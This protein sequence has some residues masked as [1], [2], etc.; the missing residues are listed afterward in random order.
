MRYSISRNDS[1]LIRSESTAKF[2]SRCSEVGTY[3]NEFNNSV[4]FFKK[5]V[6]FGA[7][8]TPPSLM[9][10]ELAS[11]GSPK[12]SS[13][14]DSCHELARLEENK[15]LQ[16]EC[17][18]LKNQLANLGEK[19]NNL[20][21]KYIQLKSKRRF[22]IEEIRGRLDASQ[23]HIQT[24][25]SQLSVQRQRL[26]AEEMFRK[27]VECDLRKV[28]EEKR[29]VCKRLL[30]AE[31]EQKESVRE[32]NILQK[33]ICMLD[34]ANSDLLAK[35]LRMKYTETTLPKITTH[36]KTSPV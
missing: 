25:Q 21:L 20:A 27:Q 6:S 33:K 18:S 14:M 30:N 8:S 10:S 22:Q 11:F 23:C 7:D 4:T 26:R 3:E 29:D 5:D 15:K 2:N 13:L 17:E 28:Q 16:S 36:D 12:L 24:L 34:T 19:Y 35:L 9:T 1:A 32:A 31:M